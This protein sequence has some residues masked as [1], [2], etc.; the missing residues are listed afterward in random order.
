MRSASTTPRSV[1]GTDPDERDRAMGVTSAGSR[2]TVRFGEEN[3]SGLEVDRDGVANNSADL[4][5][6]QEEVNLCHENDSGAGGSSRGIGSASLVECLDMTGAQLNTTNPA[7]CASGEGYVGSL[8]HADP[9]QAMSRSSSQALPQDPFHVQEPPRVDNHR[10]SDEPSNKCREKETSTPAPKREEFDVK[11][12]PESPGLREG[13]T[14]QL[15]VNLHN[16]HRSG[17]LTQKT[18]LITKILV[19]VRAKLHGS[20][21]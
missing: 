13:E 20:M 11:S 7:T 21:S 6:A 14:T 17:P 1:R 8:P 10:R 19:V 5:E 4:E 18:Q 16:C 12:E 9:R 3:A 2:E 15:Q